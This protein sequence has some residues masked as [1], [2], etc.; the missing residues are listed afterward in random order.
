MVLFKQVECSKCL[1]QYIIIIKSALCSYST[2]IKSAMF[3][4]QF[5]LSESSIF[6]EQ[7]VLLYQEVCPHL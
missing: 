3:F 4:K 6:T 2:T 1:L 5:V 7:K